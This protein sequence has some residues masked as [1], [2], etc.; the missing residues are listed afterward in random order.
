MSQTG[1]L[2]ILGT[3]LVIFGILIL[4]KTIVF[5]GGA[6]VALAIALVAAHFLGVAGRWALWLAGLFTVLA[7]PYLILRSL[8]VAFGLVGAV[9]A[10]VFKLLPLALL[11]F[12]GYLLVRSLS[13]R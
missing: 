12:G 9:V 7:L 5:G 1:L 4:V 2:G 6:L 11:M 3:L 8:G 13:R 10:L